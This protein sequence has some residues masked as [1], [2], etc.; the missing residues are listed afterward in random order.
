M[1]NIYLSLCAFNLKGCLAR[2]H[3]TSLNIENKQ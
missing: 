3:K 1:G 2:F